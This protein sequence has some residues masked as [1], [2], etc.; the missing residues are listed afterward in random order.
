MD[1]Q[2]NIVDVKATFRSFA[3]ELAIDEH[4]YCHG[5]QLTYCAF[6]A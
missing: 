5:L 3:N 1:G 2:R 4:S 6:F